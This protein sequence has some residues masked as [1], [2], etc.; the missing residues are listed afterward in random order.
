MAM[1]PLRNIGAGGLTPDQ[2]PYDVELTQFPSGNNVQFFSGRLGKSLGYTQ[3]SSLTFQPTHA[4]GWFV[5]SAN[6]VIIGSNDALYRFNGSTVENVTAT[7]YTTGYSN[8]PR[9]QS[10]QIGAGFL[11]NNGSDKPQ[12]MGSGDT[13]FADID[14]WPTSLRSYSVRPFTSFLVMAGYTEGG[15]EY[16]YTVRWSD[17]FDPTTVPGSY[18]ITSTTNLAGENILGGRFGRLVDS[19]PLAGIN[20]VYAERGAYAMSFIGAPLVFSFREL[21]D[22]DGIVNVG[23]ACVFNNRHF[24]V[25][26]N[27]I[28]IHDG[29]A[30]QSIAEKRVKEEFYTQLADTRSVFVVH[31]P[32]LAEIWVCYADKNASDKETANRALVYSYINDGFTFRDI[33]NVRSMAIGPGI[34]GGGTGEGGANSASWDSLNVEWDSWSVNWSDLGAETEARNL[35]LFAAGYADSKLFAMNET[36]GA[37][38]ATY[39]SFVE[40]SKIDLDRVLQRPVERVMQIKRIVPQIEGTGTVTFKVGS[41]NSPQSPV[42]WKTTKVFNVESDYKIDTRVSGRYL[43]IRVES[44]DVAGYW[45]LGGFDLDVEEVSER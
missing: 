28:Y 38:G 15:V 8:S 9:W 36:Y 7:A 19:L 31:D 5:D 29:S 21:F 3:V 34:G 22:D 32:V 6:S 45:Q 44:A 26:R 13:L 20:I 1:V 27:D 35:R 40:A 16:P 4:A 2:Q 12:Y 14:N 39:T 42:T 33:P 43:A 23:A 37:V 41:S 30:K 10:N 17:E 25:G 18:D 11:M 24:V